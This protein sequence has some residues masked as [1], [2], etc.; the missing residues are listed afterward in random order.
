MW[1]A[2]RCH[3]YVVNLLLKR[4]TDPLISDA[5]G[6]NI[7]HLA[8]IDG[9][10]FLLVLLLH[11]NIPVD[12]SDP[13]GHTS[14]M[15]A[16][17]KGFP[18]CVDLLLQWG[19][20]ANAIDECGFAPLHWALV[21]GSQPCIQK[22]LEY[23]ADRFAAT[24]DGKTP[25]TVANEM[26]SANVWYRALAEQGYGQDGNPKTLPLG[27][28]PLIKSRTM[29]ARFFFFWPFLVLFIVVSILSHFVVYFAIPLALLVSF[30]MQWLAGQVAKWGP[31]EYRNLHKTPFLA[32][33]FAGTLFWVGVRW[34]YAVLP[35][36]FGSYPFFNIFFG[37]FYGLTTYFYIIAMLG[38]PGYVP[39]HSSRNQQRVVIEE[40]FS[41]WKFDEDHFCV[42]CM[43]R[44]PLRSKH[45]RRCGRCVAK[46]DHHCPW[47][48]NCV[49][50]NNLRHFFLY[51]FCMEVGIL[52][53]IRL[54]IFHIEAMPSPTITTCKVVSQAFC[55]VI[56]RDP[57]TINLTIWTTL[58]LVW[59]SMLIVVQL[60]QISRNQT[61]FENMKRHS[62]DHTGHSHHRSHEAHGVVA[63]GHAAASLNDT[64]AAGSRLGPKQRRPDGCLT[65]WK[66]LLGLDA[67]MATAQD[68][69]AEA[70]TGRRRDRS[71]PFSRGIIRNCR[72]FWCDPAPI[73]G[74]R[75]TGEAMLGG[76]IVNY[77]RMYDRPLQ[78]MGRGAMLY[79]GVPSGDDGEV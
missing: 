31:P 47:I 29:V 68:G 33:V 32:G 2:Q 24:Y 53:F 74:K 16:A 55:D 73:F 57:W 19:A 17:Y 60:V 63:G 25:A 66:K 75:N 34:L 15:W 21:R 65:R 56:L 38:D 41:L 50:N 43:I 20:N 52:L 77:A 36:T 40:L 37:I 58:Q 46:H 6:Y 4:G 27:L 22:I 7:L 64:A 45:C 13:Q 78:T 18:A 11:Q 48:H 10:S 69:L 44:K 1:A 28:T 62:F 26:K 67:F 35:T 23:G 9:N 14:L 71:N 5:S 42:Q 59:V 72:D 70:S 12:I 79:S 54:V 8:A 51:I 76:E 39:K 30:S 49:A 61:T 3:Y